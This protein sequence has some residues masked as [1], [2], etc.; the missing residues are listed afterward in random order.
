MKTSE[1]RSMLGM[2]PEMAKQII[3]MIKRGKFLIDE[4]HRPVNAVKM[5]TGGHLNPE[6]KSE[7]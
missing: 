6:R 1:I 2:T 4:Q 5:K 7:A 3:P